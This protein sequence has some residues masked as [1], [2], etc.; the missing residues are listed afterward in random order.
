M[1]FCLSLFPKTR[2]RSHALLITINHIFS[3]TTRTSRTSGTSRKFRILKLLYFL[4]VRTILVMI[5]AMAVI[6]A[7]FG[8]RSAEHHT[9]KK[10]TLRRDNESDNDGY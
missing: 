9:I 8:S 7:E 10:K 3:G 1:N 5:K 6:I 2:T 4:P